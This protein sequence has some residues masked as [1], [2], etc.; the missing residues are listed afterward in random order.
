MFC[1]V[2]FQD[3]L[4]FLL[5]IVELCEVVDV[6]TESL[7]ATYVLEKMCWT[8]S[9]ENHRRLTE[10]IKQFKESD[11]FGHIFEIDNNDLKRKRIIVEIS[12][13]DKWLDIFNTLSAINVAT[14]R[15]IGTRHHLAKALHTYICLNPELKCHEYRFDDLRF[16]C[17][18]S[19]DRHFAVALERAFNE[20][21]RVGIVESFIV[22]K[23]TDKK[24]WLSF[25][26]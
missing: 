23:R 10:A 5:Y 11:V 8:N 2:S 26:T 22:E 9:G 25:N 20:L 21:L 4:D 3:R 17:V 19:P 6:K 24:W 15:M 13:K 1:E 12:A 16:T 18:K 14:R 7:S